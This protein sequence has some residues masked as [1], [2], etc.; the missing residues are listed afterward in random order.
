MN[1]GLGSL[2]S[3]FNISLTVMPLN[4]TGNGT[5]CIPRFPVPADLPIEDG[6]DATLQAITVGDSGTALYNVSSGPV[7]DR[8]QYCYVSP[9]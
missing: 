1:L 5:I 2:T 4:E 9:Y 3:A 7:V 6:T 8:F